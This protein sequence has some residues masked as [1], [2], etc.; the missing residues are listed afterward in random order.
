[1]NLNKPAPITTNTNP[2]NSTTPVILTTNSSNPK[3][4]IPNSPT[5][6]SNTKSHTLQNKPLEFL[7]VTVSDPTKVTAPNG[8]D[9]YV[10]YRITT[11]TNLPSYLNGGS[12]IDH[13]TANN[14]TLLLVNRNHNQEGGGSNGF[15]VDM[16]S[17]RYTVHHRFSEFVELRST[18][19]TT[20][21]MASV[22]PAPT[23]SVF[24]KFNYEFLNSR[25]DELNTF[26]YAISCNPYLFRSAILREFLTKEIHGMAKVEDKGTNASS[27]GVN[28]GSLITISDNPLL[29]TAEGFV[30]YLLVG[31][32]GVPGGGFFS[33]MEEDYEKVKELMKRWNVIPS[34]L[35]FEKFAI[36][37]QGTTSAGKSSYVNNFFGLTVKKAADCQQDI[38]YTICEVVSVSTFRHYINKTSDPNFVFRQF[39][40]QELK[41]PLQDIQSDWRY[42]HV[43]TYLDSPTTLSRYGT[44]LQYYSHVISAASLFQTVLINEAYLADG[45]VDDLKKKNYRD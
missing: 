33:A 35:P 22:P 31:Q 40:P 24:S 20:N 11:I 14:L 10:L 42:G 27:A 1:M 23:K 12:P 25:A 15:I 41:Y 43:F 13:R 18:L 29:S 26:M 2:T 21:P 5:S 39:Q 7:C 38:C 37:V 6:L 4:N 36:L 30:K 19:M 34:K 44:Q 9:P 16:S 45:D 17:R 8:T 3:V 32:S 28:G